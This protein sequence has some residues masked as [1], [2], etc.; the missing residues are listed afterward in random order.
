[1]PDTHE[2]ALQ[3]EINLIILIMKTNKQFYKII[4]HC[5][6]KQQCHLV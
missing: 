5:F 6:D 2:M 1:M 4:E 3:A